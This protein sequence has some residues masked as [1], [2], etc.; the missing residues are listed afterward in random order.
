MLIPD[1]IQRI[2]TGGE[3]TLAGDR[4][5][6]FTPIY[7]DDCVELLRRL[8]DMSG[9]GASG[10]FNLGGCETVDLKGIVTILG[11]HLRLTPNTRCTDAPA[12]YFVGDSR[13]LYS[14]V[15]FRPLV[16]LERGLAQTVHPVEDGA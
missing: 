5:I 4:G 3:I 14:Q 7:I 11:R 2:R 9:G 1:M 13:K 15:G 10:V 8:V 6:V 12:T 16:G